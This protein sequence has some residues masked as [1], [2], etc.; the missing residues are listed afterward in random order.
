MPL[1]LRLGVTSFGIA[2][3]IAEAVVDAG[4]EYAFIAQNGDFVTT[5]DAALII[6]ERV[7]NILLTQAGELLETQDGNNLIIQ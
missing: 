4:N 6:F 2:Q 5:Q 1:S 7:Q 3:T